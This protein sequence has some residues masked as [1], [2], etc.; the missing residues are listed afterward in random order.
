MANQLISMLDLVKLKGVDQEVGLLE[1]TITYAPELSTIM[2]RPI[3]G[4]QYKTAH[5]VLPTV[6]FRQP[7]TGTATIKGSYSQDLKECAL[8]DAQMQADMAVAQAQG[9][10]NGPEGSVQ[11]ILVAEAQGVIRATY[12]T[13]GAQMYYG[14]GADTNGFIGINS[15]T[16]ASNAAKNNNPAV[17][18]AGGTTANAQT[19]VFL[20][21]E[22]M[23]GA[24]FIFGNNSGFTMLPEWRIQQVLDA[25]SKPYTAFVNNL[26]GWIGFAINHP[27]SVARIA[28]INQTDASG[29]ANLSDKIV[30]QLLSYIPLQMRQ[31]VNAMANNGG[32]TKWG[33]S[34]KLLMNPQ[35]AYSLQ[36][37]RSAALNSTGGTAITA[38]NEL[39]FA[40]MPTESNGIPIVITDSISNTEAVIS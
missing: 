40:S 37:S 31:E 8:I 3:I 36:Q 24:H 4:T 33:P 28:N 27:N 15:V 18:K 6:S 34:L 35:T 25:N 38:A 32:P 20:I 11:D 39:V 7:N 26:Q 13:V 23:Q 16:G 9:H 29:A 17:I 12:I 22:N 21:W 1:D 30:A 5:R 10:G 2:G 14:T 19:S